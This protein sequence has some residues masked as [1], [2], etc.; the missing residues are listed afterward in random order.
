MSETSKLYNNKICVIIP[1]NY[2][3]VSEM[4][5]IKYGPILQKMS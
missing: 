1:I 4:F 3:T 5:K 2:L